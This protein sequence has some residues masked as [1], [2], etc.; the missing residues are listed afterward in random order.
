MPTSGIIP[1][2]KMLLPSV[3]VLEVKRH[4]SLKK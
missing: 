4:E 2:C 1:H 3:T